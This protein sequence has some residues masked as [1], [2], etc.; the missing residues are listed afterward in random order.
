[1]SLGPTIETLRLTLAPPVAEDF[2]AFAALLGDERVMTTLGGAQPRAV[3][4]RTFMQTAGSWAIHG[5]GFFIVRERTGGALVGRIGCHR[6]EG[7]PGTEVG[8]ALTYAAQGRGYATEAAAA[9]MDF[10]VDVLGW[11]EVI[12]CIDE[13]NTASAAVARRLGS[14]ILRP[15]R[16][17]APIERDTICWGQT[18]AAWRARRRGM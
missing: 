14:T 1:M 4:W 7:W 9:C 17:P 18:A 13:A 10:A 16:L 2:E 8:W 15:A 5:F 3:A 6:P 11:D 12:H